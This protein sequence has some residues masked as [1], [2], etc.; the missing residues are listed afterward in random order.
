MLEN[1]DN[2]TPPSILVDSFSLG[3]NNTINVSGDGETY[4]SIQDFSN[5][6]LEKDLFISVELNTVTLDSNDGRINFFIV[7]NYDPVLLH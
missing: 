7:V 4:N 2:S 3:N 5:N 6:L 1:L